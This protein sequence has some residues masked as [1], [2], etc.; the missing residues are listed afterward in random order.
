MHN[1]KLKL[2]KNFFVAELL[3]IF[4]LIP[5]L[6][7]A[8]S[9]ANGGSSSSASGG[10]SDAQTVK[11]QFEIPNPFKQDSIEG[12]IKTVVNEIL[13]PIGAAVAGL[14]VMYAG[15][16]YV[17]ARGSETQIKRAHEALLYAVI[18]AAI[19]LGAWVISN[20]ISATI[21]ELKV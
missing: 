9:S 10:G 7:F 13:M 8:Q 4:I 1:L 16:I 11:M 5:I 19:L 6:T 18:G 15:F 21:K 12:F 14:M 2:I 17:T 3:M 20:A